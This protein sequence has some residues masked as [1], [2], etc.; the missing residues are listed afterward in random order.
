MRSILWAIC[1]ALCA[2]LPAHAVTTAVPAAGLPTATDYSASVLPET[3]GIVS[4]RTLAQV[5]MVQKGINLVPAFSKDILGLDATEVKLQGFVIP[6]QV[7]D[8]QKHFLIAAV[9][10]ECQF[11]MPAGPEAVVEVV[12]KAPVKFGL[13][14]IVVAGKFSVLKNEA[15]GLLYR[16]DDAVSLGAALPA[17]AAAKPK[18]KP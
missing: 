17:E 4:W 14:P 11:C 13:A 10:A 2:A 7:G 6:L 18:A 1:L 16:L 15:G 12:A 3:A 5:E 9:P 8:G